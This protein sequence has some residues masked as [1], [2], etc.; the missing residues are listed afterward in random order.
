VELG[1]WTALAVSLAIIP[2]ELWGAA[3]GL[4]LGSD[5]LVYHV[6]L[7]ALWLQEG[8]LA[9][10]DLPFHD[11][12][13]EHSPMLSQ[14][15]IYLLM[16]LTGDDGLAWTV[17]PV[18]LFWM[19]WVFF[20]SARLLGASRRLALVVTAMMVVQPPFVDDAMMTNNDLILSSGMALAL[21]G[22]L[23]TQRRLERGAVTAC[24]GLALMLATKVIGVVYASAGLVVL[25]FLVWWQARTARREIHWQAM[26]VSMLALLLAGSVFYLRNAALYG[27]PL[28]PAIIRVGGIEVFPGLYETS[29]M[30]RHPWS[31][32]FFKQML[33]DGDN[34]FALQEPTSSLLWMGAFVS[35]L[36]LFLRRHSRV[37][38]VRAAVCVALPVLTL[39]VYFLV[40]PF[41]QEYRLLFPV[42]VILW[43]AFAHGLASIAV[44]DRHR[45]GL[46]VEVV[47]LAGAAALGWNF[48]C[49][50][51][52]LPP[53]LAILATCLVV[54]S[55]WRRRTSP[56]RWRRGNREGR[57]GASWLS[58]SRLWLPAL[59]AVVLLAAAIGPLW[60]PAY[61]A[62]LD[63]LRPSAY[64]DLYAAQG[65]AW[66]LVEA[67]TRD[68]RGKTI[69][70]AGTPLVFPLFGSRLQNRVC[71]VPLSPEE[72][73][74]PVENPTQDTLGHLL[75]R[76]RRSTVDE[77]YWLEELRRRGVDY[78]YLCGVEDP[79]VIDPE[80]TIIAK[81]RERF[82]PRFQDKDVYL[83][84]VRR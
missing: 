53:V 52:W 28:Y 66:N 1:A 42:H 79:G 16:R 62:H 75:A 78:L 55:K 67:L 50:P 2:Q 37:A 77:A 70:Y 69:A 19:Y 46:G 51:P 13:A 59:S 49:G 25:L 15:I 68:N 7:P 48:W 9:P 27:N 76:A 41:W 58:P 44:T 61:M 72:K 21:Y 3:G 71:Y 43:L 39:V 84:A 26:V 82:V 54:L 38:P 6:T 33:L 14:S 12:A 40:T 24:A 80:L 60:Y 32:A 31:L 8:Y 35:A 83:F 47:G 29:G 5:S 73:P 11:S 22:M 34:L 81:H 17:Q 23:M 63:Q 45:L 57:Q 56:P 74:R 30:A 64:E 4:S 65:R 10:V 20:R 36:A 18:F